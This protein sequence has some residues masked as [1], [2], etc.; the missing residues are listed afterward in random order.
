MAEVLWIDRLV[1]IAYMSMR[2][3]F[4]IFPAAC[5]FYFVATIHCERQ[6]AKA[7]S[8]PDGFLL[9]NSRELSAE[10]VWF[11]HQLQ[12]HLSDPSELRREALLRRIAE[13]LGR[14]DDV[15]LFELKLRNRIAHSSAPKS[16]E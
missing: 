15:G 11:T 14:W 16:F 10:L 4:A 6:L 2:D 5:N 8:L 3:S 1:H 9:C 13:R 7:G 12:Q